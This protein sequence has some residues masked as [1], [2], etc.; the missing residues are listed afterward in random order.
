VLGNPRGRLYSLGDL[1]HARRLYQQQERLARAVATAEVS[2]TASG[3]LST[4]QRPGDGTSARA[5]IAKKK[6][7][8][9]A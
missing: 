1:N 4:A 7:C 8:V 6:R 9:A 3:N 2:P 5:Y